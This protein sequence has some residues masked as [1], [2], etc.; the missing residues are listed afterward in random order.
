MILQSK[1]EPAA[2]ESLTHHNRPDDNQQFTASLL[3]SF[4]HF[5]LFFLPSH[6]RSPFACNIRLFLPYNLLMQQQCQ[7]KQYK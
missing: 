2:D 3:R 6:A 7:L 1:K 5:L 4:L